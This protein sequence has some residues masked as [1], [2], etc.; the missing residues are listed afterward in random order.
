MTKCWGS[1]YS[2]VE[3]RL[4]NRIK[5]SRKTDKGVTN[6]KEKTNS[7]GN[8]ILVTKYSSYHT[9]IMIRRSRDQG[10][11]MKKTHAEFAHCG[12]NEGLIHVVLY[13]KSSH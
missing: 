4:K 12:T 7:S 9:Y 11:Y 2:F 1:K 13:R 5:L 8:N 3:H 6:E 10:P